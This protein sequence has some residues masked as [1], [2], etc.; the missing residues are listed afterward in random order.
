MQINE[1]NYKT[2]SV[3][4]ISASVI[5]LIYS[6]ASIAN[7]TCFNINKSILTIF[8]SLLNDGWNN[9]I[10]PIKEND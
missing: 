3:I 2:I 8:V 10:R 5:W 1:W 7:T 6:I 9:L 4:L